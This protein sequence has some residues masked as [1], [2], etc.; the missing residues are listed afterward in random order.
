M[1]NIFDQYHGKK[2]ESERLTYPENYLGIHWFPSAVHDQHYHWRPHS[3]SSAT[4]CP[5]T[6]RFTPSIC[7]HDQ[8]G[9]RLVGEI[10]S[11]AKKKVR[12]VN[13]FLS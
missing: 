3:L 1:Q 7:R 12:R 9:K 6:I 2:L 8:M 5:Q 13:V 10:Y 11:V 4:T